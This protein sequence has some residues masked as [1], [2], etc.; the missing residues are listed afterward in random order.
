[1]ADTPADPE[2][3]HNELRDLA[4]RLHVN[5]VMAGCGTGLKMVENFKK[6]EKI[7]SY[8]MVL[9]SQKRRTDVT[10]YAKEDLPQAQEDYLESEKQNNDKPWIQSVL[11]SVDSVAALKRAYPNFY[12]DSL[13]FSQ[14]VDKAIG[15]S[16]GKRQR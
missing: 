15:E 4:E 3:L 6:G 10:G 2:E 1:M 12:L 16:N 7:H 9:D 11:V 13:A 5:D 14:A 8:L